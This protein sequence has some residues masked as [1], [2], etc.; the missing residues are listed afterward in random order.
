[1]TGILSWQDLAIGKELDAMVDQPLTVTDFVRYQGA[2]G[3]MNPIHHDTEFAKKAGYPGPFAVGMLQAGVMATYVTDRFGT[4]AV[5][6]FKVQFRELAWP[7]DVITYRGAVVAL[8]EADGERL[9]DLELAAA[10][11]NGEVHLRAWATVAVCLEASKSIPA[12]T[13]D[14]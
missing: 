12:A 11:P 4:E 5:R 14:G 1:V 2:S 6:R 3:D 9:A 8:R 10:R 7:Q 13:A